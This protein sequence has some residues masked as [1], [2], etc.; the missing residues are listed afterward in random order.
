MD[1]KHTFAGLISV[2][3]LIDI[4]NN[5]TGKLSGYAWIETVEVILGTPYV[6]LGV[7]IFLLWPIQAGFLKIKYGVHRIRIL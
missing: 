7:S 5:G 1:R 3:I 4:V 2:T 6:I